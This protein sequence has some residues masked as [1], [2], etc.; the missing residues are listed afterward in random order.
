[1]FNDNCNSVIISV[2]ASNKVGAVAI[3]ETSRVAF[4]VGISRISPI[5][6]PGYRKE[7]MSYMGNLRNEVLRTIKSALWY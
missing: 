1:M 5:R 3:E 6:V 4:A 2:A 7:T